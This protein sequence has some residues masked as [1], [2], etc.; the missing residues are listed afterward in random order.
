MPLLQST[1]LCLWGGLSAAG[2]VL[3]Q[4]LPMYSNW[5]RQRIPSQT[6]PLRLALR[7]GLVVATPS[8]RAAGVGLARLS[9]GVSGAPGITFPAGSVWRQ[10]LTS[11]EIRPHGGDQR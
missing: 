9:S 4:V 3:L 11:L 7:F 10:D 1:R 8:G 2:E 5:V 6:L